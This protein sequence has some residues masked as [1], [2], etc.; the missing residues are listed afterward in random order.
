MKPVV[1]KAALITGGSK[2]IG[3]ALVSRFQEEGYFIATCSSSADSH[4]KLKGDY[5]FVCDLRDRA[6]IRAQIAKLAEQTG[7][8]DV[9]INNAGIAGTNELGTEEGD[10]MWLDIM[11]VNVHGTYF[12]TRYA[13]PLIPRK[14]GRIINIASVLGLRGVP[15]ASAYCASKHAVL[16]LTKSWAHFL[17]PQGITVNAI[18]P[19]WT[20]TEMAE[21]RLKELNWSPEKVARS[22]PIGRFVKPEEVAELAVYLASEKAAATTGQSFVID[23]GGL[24]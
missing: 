2:G 22:I 11:N 19:G 13:L 24:A 14:T 23:G 6:E 1:K 10:R 5:N 9:L 3:Q 21:E 17:A 16:G 15:D 20:E 7:K 4:S 12:A 8:I 18:C